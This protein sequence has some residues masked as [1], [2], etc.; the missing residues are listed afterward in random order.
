MYMYMYTLSK[1]TP[2]NRDRKTDI[3]NNNKVVTGEYSYS[4]RHED[5][6]V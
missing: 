1:Y 3:K 4:Y 6:F 5:Q 2:T